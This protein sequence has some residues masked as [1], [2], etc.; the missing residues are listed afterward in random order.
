MP[1]S[2]EKN[3]I[4]ISK[5]FTWGLGF[6]IQDD[7][8]QELFK[9]YMRLVGDAE[10]NR[11]RVFAL[12]KSAELRKKLKTEDSDE[13]LAFIPDIDLIEQDEIIQSLIL[14]NTKYLTSDALKEV[15]ITMKKEPSSDATLEEQEE[16]QKW[17]DSYPQERENKIKEYV[18]AR[19]VEVEKELKAKDKEVLFKDLERSLIDQLCEN[20]MLLRY[21]DMCTYLGS[22]KDVEY[23]EHFFKDFS[24]FDNLPKEIKSQFNESYMSLEIGGEDLK[25]LLEA[26]Q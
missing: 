3:D 5:L 16:Y 19:V 1:A 26:M 7:K 10:L 21:R 18:N 6:P 17:I 14:F 8:G 9:V 2:I 4:D 20:E 25:K 12:R 23:K 22:F 24:E 15:K 11:A 13:R